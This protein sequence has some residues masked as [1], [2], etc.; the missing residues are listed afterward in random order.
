MTDRFLRALKASNG[1]IEVGDAVCRGLSIR[2]TPAGVKTWTFAYKLNGRMRRIT[3]GEYGEHPALGLSEARTQAD[4]RRAQRRNGDDP[5][6]LQDAERA[7]KAQT[8]LTFAELCELYIEHVKASGKLSWK[9]DE[10]YLKR[11]KA[12]F[13]SKPAASLTKRELLDFLKGIARKSKS[14]AN[15]TQSTVR[16]MWGWAV[17]GDHVPVNFLAGLKK[18]GG[19]EREKD[20]VLTTDEIQEFLT[21]LVASDF[22]I[23]ETVGLALKGIL[24]TAQRPG[25][26]AGMMLS[27]LHDLDGA[28]PHWII[29]RIR[30]KNKKT[31]HT[32]PLSP[33]AVRLIREALEASKDYAKGKNDRPV[34]A[35]R[36]ED[37]TSLARHSLSQAVRRLVKDQRFA[38]KFTKFTPHDLRRTAATLAQS[39]RVPKDHVKALLNHNDGDVTSIYARWHMFDEKREAS[40]AIEA[41]VLPLMPAPAAH[42]ALGLQFA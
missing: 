16:T 36:F 20:R 25:E 17:E 18:V 10:G 34:F 38:G 35:S 5:R 15:R 3:L 22:E 11:P 4:A 33:A 19:K 7:T 26:V 13:G 23:T 21:T 9:T 6:A 2:C 42:A 1:R 27:E 29:P 37:I 32:V 14:S 30:T 28:L 8:T 41:A 31:E 39:M 12:K 40:L 24:L